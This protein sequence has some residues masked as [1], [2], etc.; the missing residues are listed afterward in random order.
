VHTDMELWSEIRRRVLVD[1][2]SKRQVVRD[3]GI[4]WRTLAKILADPEPPGYRLRVA[5]P[6]PKLGAFTGVIDEILV[7]D[8]DAP[9][10]Q[11]HTARRIFERLRDEHGYLGGITQVRDYVAER[12][13]H[14]R[15]RELI[16]MADAFRRENAPLEPRIAERRVR[17]QLDREKLRR[18]PEGLR[19][20]PEAE[21]TVLTAISSRSS[22]RS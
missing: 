4:G 13:R 8:R 12:R 17:D 6:M 10:K 22:R 11:R 7:L 9:V 5:R 3:Y 2:V 19:G 15:S 20:V 16:E 1:G 21:K 18:G 14:S